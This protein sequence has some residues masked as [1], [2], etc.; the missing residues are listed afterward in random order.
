M[1]QSTAK[2]LGWKLVAGFLIVALLPPATMFLA[3]GRADW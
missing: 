2:S 3:A 1:A